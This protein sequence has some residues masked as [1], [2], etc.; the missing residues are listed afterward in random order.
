MPLLAGTLLRVL[1]QK[2]STNCTY[3]NWRRENYNSVLNYN[4]NF[5]IIHTPT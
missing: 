4:Y 2:L 5:F 3:W 1:K